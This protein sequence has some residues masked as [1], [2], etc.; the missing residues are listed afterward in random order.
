MSGYEKIQ[1]CKLKKE[2][3]CQIFKI[4]RISGQD[5]LQSLLSL[6][7]LKICGKGAE[8]TW[9]FSGINMESFYKHLWAVWSFFGENMNIFQMI[10]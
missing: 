10:K 2:W 4:R 7:I 8:T 9:K 1:I 3:F 6:F 5:I